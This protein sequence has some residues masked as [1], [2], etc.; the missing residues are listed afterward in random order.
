[1]REKNLM[2]RALESDFR[3]TPMRRRTFHDRHAPVVRIF[4]LNTTHTHCKGL[5]LLEGKRD[6]PLGE[7][8]RW[9]RFAPPSRLVRIMFFLSVTVIKIQQKIYNRIFRLFHKYQHIIHLF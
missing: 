9:C 7:A 1:M 6:L 8:H 2:L 4:P 3:S 5:G